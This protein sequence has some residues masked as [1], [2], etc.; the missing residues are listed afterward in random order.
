MA[1]LVPLRAIGR[2]VRV[3]GHIDDV[4][5]G[6]HYELHLEV[7]AVPAAALATHL[8][9][10]PAAAT[11][12]AMPCRAKLDNLLKRLRHDDRIGP[13]TRGKQ[14]QRVNKIGRSSD[15]FQ[16]GPNIEP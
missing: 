2:N 5:R 9:C 15:V 3:G 8:E 1:A 13:Y 12:Y 14:S 16:P 11:L 10:C 6:L 4:V 7:A